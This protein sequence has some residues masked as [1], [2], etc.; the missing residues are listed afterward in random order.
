MEVKTNTEIFLKELHVE[1]VSEKNDYILHDE[2]KKT[3]KNTNWKVVI[4]LTVMVL[5][6]GAATF[7]ISRWITARNIITDYNLD[8]FQDVDL[9][10]VLSQVNKIEKK[11]EE[12]ERELLLLRRD[13]KNEV[14]K[15]ES[16]FNQEKTLLESKGYNE[17][18]LI[19]ELKRL[20]TRKSAELLTLEETFNRDILLK[21]EEVNLFKEQIKEFDSD[22][23]QQAQEYE[24]IMANEE[25]K[26]KLEKESLIE[27]YESEIKEKEDKYSKEIEELLT[28][29]AELQETL[30]ETGLSEK[31]AQK[32]LYNPTIGEND[33]RLNWAVT[34]GYNKSLLIDEMISKQSRIQEESILSESELITYNREISE[35]N[36]L[37]GFIDDVPFENDIPRV[38][39]QLDARYYSLLDDLSSKTIQ[40]HEEKIEMVTNFEHLTE[41]MNS[42]ID[43]YK[44]FHKLLQRS[45]SYQIESLGGGDGYIITEP[46]T[47]KYYA[48][49]DPY[50]DITEGALAQIYN[51]NNQ[52]IGDI[53]LYKEGHMYTVLPLDSDIEL[54][55]LNKIFL[56]RGNN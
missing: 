27:K 46:E 48:Y 45:F 47:N 33:Y 30:K 22:K 20:E 6:L 51:H 41:D 50:L 35:W 32:E 42:V 25:K 43:N 49:M 40:F 11:K 13:Y 1:S 10:G 39:E 3:P 24:N 17:E 8:E 26:F 21:E 5:A 36:R 19:L 37:V 31:I 14:L 16:H 23:I 9:M 53:K 52:Y 56:T 29:Q 15:I 28:F 18:E 7:G 4:I 34:T 12:A 38:L 44:M 2:F 54:N 55:E